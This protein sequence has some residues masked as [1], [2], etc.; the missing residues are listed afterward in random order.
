MNEVR[1]TTMRAMRAMRAALHDALKQLSESDTSTAPVSVQ[2]HTYSYGQ[3]LQDNPSATREE[4][5]RALRRFL[6]RTRS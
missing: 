5:R 3:F 4:R 2:Q 1:S 6:D